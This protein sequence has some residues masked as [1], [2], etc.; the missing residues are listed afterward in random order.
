M[1]S[2]AWGKFGTSLLPESYSH[3]R[4]EQ[5]RNMVVQRLGRFFDRH[6]VVCGAVFLVVYFGGML[7]N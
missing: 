7:I 1:A 3:D 5:R 4:S 2:H 6:P